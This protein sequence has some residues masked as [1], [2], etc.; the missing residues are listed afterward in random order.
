MDNYFVVNV[1]DDKVDQKIIIN[2]FSLIFLVLIHLN[3][4]E[5]EMNYRNVII[6]KIVIVRKVNFYD[7]FY[8]PIVI[9]IIY[10]LNGK[11]DKDIH[12]LKIVE[13]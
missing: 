12:I 9:E 8:I 5:V 2:V 3:I 4:N 13:V 7:V 11:R 10:V 1:I 6:D